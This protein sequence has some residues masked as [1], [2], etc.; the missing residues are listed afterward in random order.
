MDSEAALFDEAFGSDFTLKTVVN[1][2]AQ[3]GKGAR[4]RE[5][6]RETQG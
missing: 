2:K 1:A 3:R 4:D 6:A 5:M